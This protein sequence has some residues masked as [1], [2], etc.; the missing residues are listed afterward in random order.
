MPRSRRPQ[1]RRR[2][3]ASRSAG[4]ISQ[5]PPSGL[6][7]PM[8]MGGKRS[9]RWVI[10]AIAGFLA[11]VIIGAFVVEGLFGLL[12]DPGRGTDSYKK[13]VGEEQPRM[14][15]LQ[16]EV[17]GGGRIL[18]AGSEDSRHDLEIWPEYSTVPPTSGP[19]LG[20]PWNCGFFLPGY[21]DPVTEREGVPD[22]AIVHN[23]EHGNVVMSYNLPSEDDIDRL[24]QVH[25]GLLDSDQWLITP[26]LTTRLPRAKLP[27]PRGVWW[28]YST[29]WMRGAS[30]PSTKPTEETASAKRRVAWAGAYLASALQPAMER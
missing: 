10:Y 22:R 28:I 30:S 5:I 21:I 1:R 20:R 4:G 19:H 14:T 3:S 18:P 15:L 26:S 9:R 29:V 17:I 6:R 13:G 2:S 7:G 27:W 23:L 8:S 24:R 12:P 16:D 25:F 11:V